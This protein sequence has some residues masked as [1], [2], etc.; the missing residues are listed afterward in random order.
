MKTEKLL[1]AVLIVIIFTATVYTKVFS[2]NNG[3]REAAGKASVEQGNSSGQLIAESSPAKSS[4]IQYKKYCNARFG[5]ALSYPDIFTESCES[6]N[7]DGI[8][9]KAVDD[10][11]TLKIWGSNNINNSTGK[12]LLA[13]AKNRVSHISAE[14]ADGNFFR[15]EYGGGGN[16]KEITFYECGLVSGDKIFSFLF[17]YPADEKER[18]APVVTRMT[19]EL[20]K[21][22]AKKA[23]QA[24]A[25]YA[26]LLKALC[27]SEVLHYNSF[28]VQA[29]RA[30]I[31]YT[32]F[33]LVSKGDFRWKD[34]LKPE[35]GSIYFSR[36]PE[37]E[38][39]DTT[40]RTYIA[41]EK[42]YID[43]FAGGKYEYPD[44]EIDH[45]VSGN[46]MGMAVRLTKL[47]YDV[48]VKV[49]NISVKN[50]KTIIDAEISRI[51]IKDGKQ[52]AVGNAV[53]TL[54]KDTKGF[55][56]YKIVSFQPKYS[57][58]ADLKVGVGK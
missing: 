4:K 17:S 9:Y 16:G 51:S 2:N 24:N 25:A 1:I 40:G 10:T 48:D 35:D 49:N 15:I 42:L 22:G 34:K 56:G 37:S 55:F 3:G 11:Y 31:N 30:T 45:L 13:D 14:K 47:P 27:L 29:D 46:Q 23:E 57:R 26:P 5:F 53:I 58:F 43:Y 7:G 33:S 19:D 38:E 54:K 20:K 39:A 8:T 18:F 12:T 41:P 50:D 36:G 28:N 32:I 6:D 44:I 21:N 52:T